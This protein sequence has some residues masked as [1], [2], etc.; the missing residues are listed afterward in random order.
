MN[1]IAERI[2]DFLKGFPPFNLLNR[3]QLLAVAQAVDV[4]Y[5]EK[6]TT[7][8]D[9]NQPIENHFYVVKDGAVGL[10]R[11]N[12]ALVDECDEGDIFGLRALL[13]KGS[14]ILQAKTLEESILYSISSNL[15]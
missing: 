14:Y 7:I 5:L 13:R 3:D 8:F 2:Y 4:I 15:L 12:N 6:D 10:Y 1:T 9:M 11:E